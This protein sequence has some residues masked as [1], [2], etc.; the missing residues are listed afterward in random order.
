[1]TGKEKGEKV[2]EVEKDCKEEYRK[3]MQRGSLK[4]GLVFLWWSC[5]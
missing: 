3:G 2:D 4:G 1:M 5:D